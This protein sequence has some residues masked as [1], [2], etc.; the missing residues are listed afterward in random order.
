MISNFFKHNFFLL[1]TTKI[2]LKVFEILYGTRNT[3][4]KSIQ[5]YTRNIELYLFQTLFKSKSA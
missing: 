5:S 4:I 2:I 1:S 3:I